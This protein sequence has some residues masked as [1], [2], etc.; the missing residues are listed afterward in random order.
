[1]IGV[2]FRSVS[3]GSVDEAPICQNLTDLSQDAE[4]REEGEENAREVIYQ[5]GQ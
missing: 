1:V 3:T 4:M 2:D 5:Y